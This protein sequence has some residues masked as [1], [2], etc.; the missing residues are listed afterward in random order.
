MRPRP[1]VALHLWGNFTH[2]DQ[3]ALPPTARA[4]TAGLLGRACQGTNARDRPLVPYILATSAVAKSQASGNAQSVSR[5]ANKCL[6]QRGACT[7]AALFATAG[8]CVEAATTTQPSAGY[9]GAPSP[10]LLPFPT[11]REPV[12]PLW[13]PT[14]L[15]APLTFSSRSTARSSPT[16]SKMDIDGS[17]ARLGVG[18]QASTANSG[19]DEAVYEYLAA[20]TLA[21]KLAFT[22]VSHVLKRPTRKASPFA[23][24]T[25]NP[26]VTII[27]T[28]LSTL[29]KQNATLSVLEELAV[30]FTTVPS[31]LT[32]FVFHARLCDREPPLDNHRA[33]PRH[34]GARRPLGEHILARGGS[35]SCNAI[36]DFAPS[37][38]S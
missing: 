29:T 9:A 35:K 12:L 37:I 24:S 10:P 34:H 23:R 19:I 6:M 22:M 15:S 17:H 20:L 11:S 32:L 38:Q 16:S 18:L 31:H 3:R 5:L 25:I 28:F 7:L 4:R 26:Y 27:L 1:H 14:H 8:V 30:F 36:T 2:S 21:A 13:P 33:P